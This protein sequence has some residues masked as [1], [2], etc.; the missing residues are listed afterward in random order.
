L[1]PKFVTQLALIHDDAQWIGP[2]VFQPT[3]TIMPRSLLV[4]GRLTYRYRDVNLNLELLS[5]NGQQ[6]SLGLEY[7]L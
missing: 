4:Q 3:R 2:S 7:G 5:G 1:N 6:M